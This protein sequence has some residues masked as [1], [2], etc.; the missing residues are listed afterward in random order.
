MKNRGRMTLGMRM[1]RMG[2]C[3]CAAMSPRRV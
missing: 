2:M 1:R 3:F